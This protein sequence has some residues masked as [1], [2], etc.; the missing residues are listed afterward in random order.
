MKQTIKDIVPSE[1]WSFCRRGKHSLLR[2]VRCAFEKL[3]LVVTRKQ[4]YY[5]PTPRFIYS[6]GS[7]TLTKPTQL[8]KIL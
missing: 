3:G 2:L 7:L 1:F 5:A 6:R 8:F 4:D